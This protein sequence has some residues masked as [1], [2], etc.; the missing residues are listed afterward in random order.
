MTNSFSITSATY[1]PS[2]PAS[3][4]PLNN[5]PLI[6]IR[7]TVNGTSIST[8]VYWNEAQIAFASQGTSGVQSLLAYRMLTAYAVIVGNYFLSQ[9]PQPA[10]PVT[11]QQLVNLPQPLTGQGQPNAQ[12]ANAQ[13][14]LNCGS[15]QV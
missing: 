5:D 7:G 1:N 12:P 9:G 4:I 2:F 8:Y 11:A 6:V 15:W 10:F 14:I 3:P 13:L